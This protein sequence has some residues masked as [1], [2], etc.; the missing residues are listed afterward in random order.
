[1]SKIKEWIGIHIEY[2]LGA[3]PVAIILLSFVAVAIYYSCNI[4]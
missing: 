4:Q 1:M 2:F 3:I